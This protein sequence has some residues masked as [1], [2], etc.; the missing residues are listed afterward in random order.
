MHQPS[1]VARLA[2]EQF[3]EHAVS[4]ATSP[5]MNDVDALASLLDLAAAGPGERV[6][7]AACGPGIVA[8]ELAAAGA[9]VV[10]VD[11]TPAMIELATERAAERDVAG[12][13]RFELGAMEA[14]PFAD[15]TFDVVVSRYALHHAADPAVVAAEL[16]RVCAP[17]GRVVVVD[18]AATEDRTA[19][20]AYDDAERLRDP[21]HVRNLTAAEQRSLFEAS[22]WSA[23]RTVAYQLPADL[24]TVLARSHGVDHAGV[25]R[26]FEASLD[27]HGMGVGA[28]RDGDGIT[29]TY[30]IAGF[31]FVAGATDRAH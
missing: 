2:V 28:R 25:R 1:P 5:L 14:L 26:A 24:D 27:G 29:F 19:A 30:P 4:F 8:C 11:L 7:D 15:G 13:C 6:L 20:T 16:V 31:R 23:E 18:F 10:G 22:G 3:S 12:R 17:G 21:S 9:E